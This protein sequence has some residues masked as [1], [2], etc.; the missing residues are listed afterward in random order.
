MQMI[1]HPLQTVAHPYPVGTPGLAVLAAGGILFFALLLKRRRGTRGE[2]AAKSRSLAS[3][4]GILVQMLGFMTVGIGPI[5]A[6]LRPASAPALLHAAIVAALMGASVSLFFAATRAMG[7]NWSFVARM[8]SG[9]ELVTSGVFGFVRHP[10]YVGMALF[11]VALAFGFGHM[12]NLVAGV[13]IFLIGTWIRVHQEEKLLRAEFG[14]AY[15]D[16]AL[17]VKRFVPGLI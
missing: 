15:E 7:E 14:Q 3:I 1:A 17:R 13:P 9:H 2:G 5:L 10:I 6:T 12:A 4:A 16:Y 11:L 8:R